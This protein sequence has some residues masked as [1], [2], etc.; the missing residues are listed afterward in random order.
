MPWNQQGGGGPWGQGPRGPQPPS[1]E[2]LLRR[3][4]DRFRGAL[5]SGGSKRMIVLVLVVLVAVWVGSGF[6]RVGTD[7]QGVV[8][9]FG[10]WVE[11][12]K[13]GLNYHLPTPI[14]SV[15]TP[16]VTRV[17]RADVGFRGATE[18]GRG[19]A[20]RDIAEESLMLTGDENIVDIDFTVFWVIRDAG[21]FLFNITQPEANVKAVAESAM[22]EVVGKTP[23]QRAVTEGRAQIEADVRT[24]AQ[25]ILDGY[26]AGIQINEVKLQKV[27]PP[28]AVIDAFRDVQRARADLERQ[29]NEAEAYANDILP[30]ARGEREQMLQ[31]A[32]AYKEETVA[33][34][35]G[36]ASRFTAIYNEFAKAKDVTQRRI[37]L[38]TMERVLRGSQKVLVDQSPGGGG[39]VP[40]LPLPELQRKKEGK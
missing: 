13:P 4:Q 25:G 23:F 10:K 39:V 31:E 32:Q 7:E 38:E 8:L 40:Y 37:Y 21:Q 2:D 6:Y 1:L 9:R 3:S 29:K 22:R 28:G 14:E 11:T 16:K 26:K 15:E 20:Q 35:L 18:T 27:D 34:A 30:R 17:N 24:L 5:P 19:T 33:R 36:D 12:T